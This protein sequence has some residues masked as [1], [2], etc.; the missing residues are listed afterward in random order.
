MACLR[1][2]LSGAEMDTA[3]ALAMATAQGVQPATAAA[4][5]NDFLAG[6]AVGMA[7]RKTEPSADQ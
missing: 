5:L 7:A 2:G 6:M 4:L 1:G 3:G